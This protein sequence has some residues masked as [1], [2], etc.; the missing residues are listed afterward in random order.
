MNNP[1]I[2]LLYSKVVNEY[3]K[4][5]SNYSFTSYK[6]TDYETVYVI[7]DLFVIYLGLVSFSTHSEPGNYMVVFEELLDNSIFKFNFSG[8][9]RKFSSEETTYIMYKRFHGNWEE[10]IRDIND[11]NYGILSSE[12]IQ[13]LTSYHIESKA[14]YVNN[15]L[16][17]LK[18]K[19]RYEQWE[20]YLY[21]IIIYELSN[22][23]KTGYATYC[24]KNPQ[25]HKIARK[26]ANDVEWCALDCYS[27]PY[28]QKNK[29]VYS[30][31]GEFTYASVNCDK[32]MIELLI[33]K[34]EEHKKNN[35]KDTKTCGKLCIAEHDLKYFYLRQYFRTTGNLSIDMSGSIMQAVR[36]GYYKNEPRYEYT[37]QGN[38]W[39]SEEL[40]YELTK[41]LFKENT[42][43]YQYRPFF[44]K[45]EKGQMSYDVFICGLNIAIEYQ[46]KQHFE[47]VELFGGEDSYKK[48]VVRDKLKWKLSKENNITLV[49]INYLD[50]ISSVLI[51]EKIDI[52]LKKKN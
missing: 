14:K 26:K 29:I 6:I 44:L 5:I 50:D 13:K 31:M 28:Y 3:E 19:E 39:K 51:R 18:L 38:K 35:W 24:S 37:I 7:Q 42:V 20:G 4:V 41:K 45:S 30:P 43:L 46:G 10:P 11:L 23:V 2:Y 25:V 48:Q 32:T 49:Y 9:S 22:G 1:D 52:A 8:F 34:I 47:P 27:S 40:V 17:Q 12:Q 36:N 16:P 15:N 33:D 21:N